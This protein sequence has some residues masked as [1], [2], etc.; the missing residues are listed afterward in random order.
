MGIVVPRLRNFGMEGGFSSWLSTQEYRPH[1]PTQC[2][3]KPAH[4]PSGTVRDY[5]EL[6]DGTGFRDA[7]N[8]ITHICRKLTEVPVTAAAGRRGS[9][10][11]RNNIGSGSRAM[12]VS[13]K[14]RWKPRWAITWRKW[15]T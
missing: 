4:Y 8:S 1:Q 12:F 6:S 3:Y 13:S 10:P 9:K 2:R 5:I 15:I 14:P 7:D 11:G